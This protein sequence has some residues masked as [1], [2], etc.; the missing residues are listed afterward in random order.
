[1]QDSFRQWLSDRDECSID[2]A[3]FEKECP[4]VF[5]VDW[6]EDD[7]DVVQKCGDCLVDESIRGEWRDNT[8]VIIRGGNETP[9]QLANNGGDRD[10]T[11]R[12][13]NEVLQPD[14]EIRLLVSSHGSDT[15]GLAVLAAADWEFLDAEMAQAVYENFVKLELLPNMFTE[16]TDQHLPE[17]ARRRFKRMLARNRKSQTVRPWWR[18]W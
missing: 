5:A 7:A 1:M 11:I 18:F 16:M 13:L 12:T 3:Y 14:Y 9:V 8:L 17:P 4:H 6:G 15:V 10:V 2:A